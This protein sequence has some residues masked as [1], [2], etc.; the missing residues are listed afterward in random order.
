MGKNHNGI[1]IL[2]AA[3]SCLALACAA[4]TAHAQNDGAKDDQEH[5]FILEIGTAGE[6]PFSDRPNFGGTFAIETTPIENWLELEFGLTTLAT[7]GRTEMSGDLLFKKPFELSPTVEF[8]I[9]AGPSISKTLNGPDQTISVSPEV[10]LDFMFWPTKNI[11]WFVE[12]T[13]SVNPRNGQQ[14]AAVNVGILVGFPQ[15]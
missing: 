10:A 14:S 12:P 2:A 9:G 3:A 11:G 4:N 7:A 15:R 13:W 1:A 6:W 5:A 8:M